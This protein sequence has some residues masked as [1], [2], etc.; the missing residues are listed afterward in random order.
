[1]AKGQK[2]ECTALRI[3]LIIG[4]SFTVLLI[5]CLILSYTS[6]LDTFLIERAVGTYK[7]DSIHTEEDGVSKTINKGENYYLGFYAIELTEDYAA[8]TLNKDGTFQFTASLFGG[9]EETFF[10][11]TWSRDMDKIILSCTNGEEKIYVTNKNRIILNED[12]VELVLLKQG[13]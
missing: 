5:G 2:K 12:G 9:T 7:F 4:L 6:A 1:M 8:L 3:V 11:G 10:S 13:I